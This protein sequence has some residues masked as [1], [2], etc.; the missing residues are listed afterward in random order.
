MSLLK[1]TAI[2]SIFTLISRITGFIRDMVMAIFFGASIWTDAFLVA[3]KIPNFMRRLFA[4]GSFSLAFVPVLNDI[5]A[6]ESKQVLKQFID[7]I[8][9]SLLAVVLIVW[10][11]MEIFAPQVL[12]LFAYKWIAE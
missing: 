3:F 12:S 1:S 2:V 7:R 10:M 9:G 5:K 4:E 11:L 6:T 8:A